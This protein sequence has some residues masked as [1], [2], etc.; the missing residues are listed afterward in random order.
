MAADHVDVVIT[1]NK[2]LHRVY[3]VPR[4]VVTE[5]HKQIAGRKEPL[6]ALPLA[7]PSDEDAPFIE[8]EMP[9]IKGGHEK[10]R[11]LPVSRTSTL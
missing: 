8:D 3:Q 1:D 11:K 10:L 2:P 4:G 9:S 6:S 7:A 5:S